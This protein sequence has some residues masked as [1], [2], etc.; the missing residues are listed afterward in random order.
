MSFE[1]VVYVDQ[2]LRKLAC[3]RAQNEHE[4]C[5]WLRRGFVERVHEVGAFASFREYAERVFGFSARQTE[6]RLRVAEALERLPELNERFASGELGWSQ[7]R[8]LTRVATAE[9]EAQW[10]E[11]AIDRTAHEVERLVAGRE[12]GETPDGPSR[13]EAKLERVQVTVSAATFADWQEGKRKA[14][15]DLGHTIDDETFLAMVLRSYL[16]AGTDDGRSNYQISIQVCDR[17]G[18]AEQR[19]GGSTVVIDAADLATASCDAQH[20][21]S[22]APAPQKRA[23][24]SQSVPPTSRRAV[25]ARHQHRCAVPGCRHA[26]FVDLHHVN[27]RAEGGDHNEDFL[28][29]LCSAHHKLEHRGKLV[30]RGSYSTG[31]TFEHADGRVYG[32]STIDAARAIAFTQLFD[33]L[34]AMGFK[35]TESRRLIDAVRPHVGAD[36][37]MPE[38]LH[39]TLR[40]APV[41]GVRE[42]VEVYTRLA[43]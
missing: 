43:S 38:L 24:A 5:V 17:C 18:T 10:V 3:R 33:A 26:T 19:A 1:S 2:K 23:R 30:I 27:P 31:F 9:T 12:L 4:T 20:I 22:T 6:E 41:H 34:R 11:T 37:K 36:V 35:E 7:V 13:P 39:E 42:D 28:V 29:P 21:G 25:L 16:G 8:E 14:A 32:S 40:R 15:R